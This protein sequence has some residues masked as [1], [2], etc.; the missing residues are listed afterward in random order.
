MRLVFAC[1]FGFLLITHQLSAQS[2]EGRQIFLT[3]GVG[4]SYLNVREQAHSPLLYNGLGGNAQLGH[5]RNTKKSF[6]QS[7]ARFDF[8]AVGRNENAASLYSYKFE[9]QYQHYFKQFSNADRSIRIYP[10]LAVLGVWRLQDH[11]NFTNNSQVITTQFSLAPAVKMEWPFALFNR[12]FELGFFS[13][14]PLLNYIGRPLFASTKFPDQVNNED[15]AWHNYIT[16]GK[17]YSLGGYFNI[18]TQSYLTYAFKNGNGLK[19]DYF[20][21]FESLQSQNPMKAGGHS[22]VISTLFKL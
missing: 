20:W 11:L 2:E 4:G 21:S 1:C 9:G 18:R 12:N 14:L 15:P 13:Q 7:I 19:L 8:N 5:I 16:G 10:G 17:L 22:L 6:S 3:T